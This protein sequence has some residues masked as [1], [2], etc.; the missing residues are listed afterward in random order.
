MRG[1]DTDRA[2]ARPGTRGADPRRCERRRRARS[3]RVRGEHPRY[4]AV[5]DRLRAAGRDDEVLGWTERGRRE[6]RISDRLGEEGRDYWLLPGEV[7]D[8]YLAA[9][10]ERDALDVLRSA[11]AASPGFAAF[12]R[13]LSF[14][15]PLGLR[16]AERAACAPEFGDRG[17]SADPR[18]RE[19]PGS[20]I[21]AF[22][23]ANT[24]A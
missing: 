23:D 3:P 10:R 8:T 12:T 9:G 6:H 7:A 20:A 19:R 15:E 14:A 24:S 5:I 4:G 13:L 17:G 1:G 11:F 21:A 18:H 2:P 16:H 22:A